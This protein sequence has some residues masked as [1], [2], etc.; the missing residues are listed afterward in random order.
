MANPLRQSSTTM[1]KHPDGWS[2]GWKCLSPVILAVV[3]TGC[4]NTKYSMEPPSAKL[5]LG[6]EFIPAGEEAQI[7]QIVE[8]HRHVQ[9]Q[10]D[11]KLSPVPRGQHQKQ[12]GCVEAEFVVESNLPQPLRHGLF[13]EPRT[14]RALIRFS[15][16]R[17][18]DDRKPDAHG[19][20]IKLLDV[21]G[22]KV[23]ATDPEAQTQDFVM[24]D[25]PVFFVKNNADYIPLMKDF[26]RLATGNILTKILTG[27]KGLVSPDY[28]FA[29]LREIGS[30]RPDSPLAI[31]YWSTTPSKLDLGA[32]KFSARPA[33]DGIPDPPPA[34]SKDKLRLAMSAHLKER[35]ARFDFLVQ[36]Q[37]DP[38][39]MPVEDPTVPW[40]ETASPYVKV[41]TIR[42]PIQ[43]FESDE[44]MQFGEN[45][46][47]T[48]WHALAEHRPLGGIN[49]A[50]KKVYEA[51]SA[52][53]H[54]LN[55]VS[56]REPT[57]GR[58]EKE[59]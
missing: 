32:M 41:A 58:N 24:I 27:V 49:R 36:I 55:G 48:P 17:A 38:L 53:R 12:H 51:I 15:N 33:L 47:F 21:E 1:M 6:E 52:R 42:I 31:Q 57:A 3:L 54:E 18:W 22:A 59:P 43:S 23:F 16:G 39:A 46:S 44:Q 28:R 56:H 7:D 8:I 29:L 26:S 14:Y 34:N 50:R 19:M 35:E 37:T 10:A 4:I 2:E 5:R 40:D 20:A 11:R 13:R 25:S 45:L 9:E 30:K